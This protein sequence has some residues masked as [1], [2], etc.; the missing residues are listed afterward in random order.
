MRTI[1]LLFTQNK[2]TMKKTILILCLIIINS[3][4]I[5]AQE[6]ESE[7]KKEKQTK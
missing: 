6:S 7:A 2:I 5:Q 4:V 1:L 3:F